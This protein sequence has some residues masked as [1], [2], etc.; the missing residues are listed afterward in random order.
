M[1]APADRWVPDPAEPARR[2]AVWPEAVLDRAAAAAMAAEV[3][4][5]NACSAW[6]LSRELETPLRTAAWSRPSRW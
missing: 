5:S 4:E 2:A 1:A 3:P 6:A